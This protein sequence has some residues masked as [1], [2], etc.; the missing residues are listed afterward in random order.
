MKDAKII[1]SMCSIPLILPLYALAK[2][3]GFK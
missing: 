3:E 2:E 1:T